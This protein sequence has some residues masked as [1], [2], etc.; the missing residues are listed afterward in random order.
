M[1]VG[2]GSSQSSP[3]VS[4]HFFCASPSNSSLVLSLDGDGLD[5]SGGPWESISSISS[6]LVF[7]LGGGDGDLRGGGDLRIFLSA[8]K[9]PDFVDS[10]DDEAL[11][12]PRDAKKTMARMLAVEYFM[13]VGCQVVVDV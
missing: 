1:E 3:P 7:G 13:V 9:V 4:F 12:P 11:M 6:C 2:L 10:D 5:G 8:S